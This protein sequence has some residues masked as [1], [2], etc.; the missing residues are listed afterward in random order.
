MNAAI[1]AVRSSR[2]KR[3]YLLFQESPFLF[4]INFVSPLVFRRFYHHVEAPGRP[5]SVWLLFA[6]PINYNHL[7]KEEKMQKHTK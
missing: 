4:D 1:S 2:K 5:M 3:L 6:D 7:F